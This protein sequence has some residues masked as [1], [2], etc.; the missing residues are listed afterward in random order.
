[1]S[2][3]LTA[4]I[5]HGCCEQIFAELANAGVSWWEYPTLIDAIE[6]HV[7]AALLTPN[8]PHVD[9]TGACA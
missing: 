6:E 1:M 3:D 2:G 5:A 4:V 9:M 7:L 8:Q